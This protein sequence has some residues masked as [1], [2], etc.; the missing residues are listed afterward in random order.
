MRLAY[1]DESYTRDV[2]FLGALLV[3]DQCVLSLGKALDDVVEQAGLAHPEANITR[4][5][6]LHA[7]AI[8]H[9]RDEWEPLAGKVRARISIYD[10]ALRV[11]GDHDIRVILCGVERTPATQLS[12]VCERALGLLLQRLNRF[13]HLVDEPILVISDEVGGQDLHRSSLR[14]SRG[15]HFQGHPS[16]RLDRIVDTL[17]FVPSAQS[18]FIQAIDL[19]TFLHC[20]RYRSIDINPQ[21]IRA[22]DLLWGRIAGKI[23]EL[24]VYDQDGRVPV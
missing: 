23:H 12:Q 10:Q 17:H 24:R 2:Y 8:F 9:S 13:G 3:D 21:A 14:Q 18:R 19:V 15:P 6:E 7:Y 5:A 11:I 20:R 16:R 4:D 1:V 22:N